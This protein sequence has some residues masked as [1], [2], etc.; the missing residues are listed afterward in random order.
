MAINETPRQPEYAAAPPPP[1]TGLE[2]AS[3]AANSG[4]VIA[5]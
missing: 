1:G 5:L 2:L 4:R 3:L